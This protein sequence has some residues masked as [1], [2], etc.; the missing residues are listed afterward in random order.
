MRKVHKYIILGFCSYI[1]S[2]F[3]GNK[4]PK[5]VSCGAT[6][7]RMGKTK[8][9]YNSSW[10]KVDESTGEALCTACEETV[11]LID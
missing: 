5:C 8:D 2:F 1:F 4:A 9:G 3:S 7:F 6:D 11:E 10:A